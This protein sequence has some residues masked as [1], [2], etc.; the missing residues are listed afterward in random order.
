MKNAILRAHKFLYGANNKYS[1]KKNNL[2]LWFICNV[3]F[4]IAGL[5]LM[6]YLETYKKLGIYPKPLYNKNGPCI[7]LTTFPKRINKV[8]MVVDSMFYQKMLPSKICLYLSKEEFPNG[9][10]SLPKR[11]LKYE[12]LGLEICF[13][14]FNLMP[15]TKYFY[16]LQEY[17]DKCIITIDDDIYYHNDMISNLMELHQKNPDCVCSNTI[18]IMSFDED[19]D[20]TPYNNWKRS[21][22]PRSPSHYN[23]ALGYDGVLY[24][25]Y[26]FKNAHEMFNVDNIKSLSLKADDIWLKM[27]EIL[28]GIKVVSGN[29]YTTGPFIIGSQTISLMSTNCTG[30]NDKQLQR[31][32]SYYHISRSMIERIEDNKYICNL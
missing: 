23:V 8:W 5:L 14:E 28:L 6:G 9:R 24:P 10:A 16:A 20:P 4:R 1:Y 21:I 32:I 12:N 15:H 13:R 11:L 22:T 31:L 17:P 25:A 26:L 19:G 18:N 29:H 27:H 7:S 3:L 30:G 2:L